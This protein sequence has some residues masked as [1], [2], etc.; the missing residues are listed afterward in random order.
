MWPQWTNMLSL[1][2]WGIF[3]LVPPA[4]VALYFLKLRRQPVE[5]PSTYLW[6]KSIEDLHVN[7]LWQRLRQNLLLFLQL[8]VVAL[9]MLA[10]LRP[11]WLGSRLVGDRFI[12]LVDTSASMAARDV[13]PTRLEDA[14]RQI[15]RIID[16]MRSSDTA[17]IVSFSDR[18]RV[19]QPF[20]SDRRALR[21]R[22]DEIAQTAKATSL[23][24]ALRVAAGLANPGR[25]GDISETQV[26]EPMP[27]VLYIFSDGNFDQVTDF[28]LGNLD[29]VYVRIGQNQVSNVGIIAFSAESSE[30]NPDRLQ[31]FGRLVNFGDRD[32]SATVELL[33]DGELIDADQ[34]TIAAGE[35]Q[36]V[37]FELDHLD[38]AE[39]EFRITADDHF[40]LDDRAWVAV[41]PTRRARVL[42]V[43][44]GNEP[45]ELALTTL[46]A[47][48]V[49]EVEFVAPD[50]LQGEEYPLRSSRGEFDLVIYDRC[51]PAQPPQSNTLFIGSLPPGE[52][53]SSGEPVD[54]PLIIDVE[55]AHPLMSL[56]ALGDVQVLEATPVVA[57]PG[58]TALIESH[59]GTLLA[60]AP[61]EGFEDA[62]LGFELMNE[63]TPKTTWPLRAS[64]PVFI[65]NALTYLGNPTTASTAASNHR[66]GEPI[67]VRDPI[68]GERLRMETPSARRL[69]VRGNEAQVVNFTG[70][71]ELGIYRL[72]AGS[73][74]QRRFAVNLFDRSE[75]DIRPAA[76]NTIQI[77]DVKVAGRE[78]REASRRDLWKAVLLLALVALLVEWYIY[79]RRVYI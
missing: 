68:G 21:R 63:D 32:A 73:E 24:E 64:F 25:S 61:R 67:V 62:V 41:N 60:I 48:L 26:T 31:A 47:E 71:E 27:A 66:P 46:R 52:A 30:D 2:Q 69:E 70:T 14:K 7:S 36:G 23:D 45:L 13:E 16:Q 79:N 50:Y 5:V 20:T 8:L 40:V 18:A 78:A 35:E 22:L 74:V 28:S 55:P 34:V 59:L 49:A 39:L 76:E 29:P 56:V 12:F 33:L 65:M 57:P 3:A 75:S 6:L 17:M 38:S 44:P 77:G 19:E 11:S 51:R 42:C 9:A 43:T 53:W 10:V 15:G 72:Q 58:H 37:L 4:I 54:L 1:W